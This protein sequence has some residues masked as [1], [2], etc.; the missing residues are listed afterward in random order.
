MT[1]FQVDLGRLTDVI[2][3]ATQGSPKFNQYVKEYYVLY[4]DDGKVFKYVSNADGTK[5]VSIIPYISIS[6]T[7]DLVET[8]RTAKQN[9]M[10]YC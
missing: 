10:Y 7:T 6:L 9:K 5:L 2:G 3:V 1:I 4:S 8:K